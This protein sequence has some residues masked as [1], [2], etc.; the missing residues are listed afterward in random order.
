MLVKGG[1][2][3]AGGAVLGR[4]G[5]GL[6]G[7]LGLPGATAGVRSQLPAKAPSTRQSVVVHRVRLAGVIPPAKTAESA[8]ALAESGPATSLQAA[9]S[10][11]HLF[12]G[13]G[14]TQ[15]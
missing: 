6:T 3:A 1:G 8:D 2:L 15:S 10:G 4:I 7:T 14:S 12:T 5:A 13:G 11:R 9:Q